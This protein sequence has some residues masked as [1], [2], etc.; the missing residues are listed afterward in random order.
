ML[1][2]QKL[3]DF[4]LKELK[5]DKIAIGSI[6]RLKNAPPDMNPLNMMP[7]A[8]SVI[9]FA[10]RILRG[11]YRGID[12]GTHWPS[13]QV[14]GYSGLN[15][16]NSK[17][18]YRLGR[19]VESFGYEAMPAPSSAS[20]REFGPRGPS[21]K[22]GKPPREITLNLRI[23]AAS[24][25]LGEIGWSKVFLTEEFGPRQRIGIILTEAELEPDPIPEKKLCDGC[26]QCVR[27]CPGCAL[28]KDKSVEIELNG[29][30]V[31]WCDIDIG[32]C[33]LT[34]F[35]LNRKSSPHFVKR[36]PGVYLPVEQQ[37][38]TWLEAW[39]LGWAIFPFVPTYASL[40]SHPVPIC[41]ARGCIVACMKHLEKKGV[42]KNQ[43]VNKRG[44]SDNKPWSLPEKPPHT[45]H[46]GFVYE[47]KYQSSEDG[48]DSFAPPSDWY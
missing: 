47:P 29:K 17:T 22:P 41:G 36:F 15:H 25:G 6:E 13:Y 34:H 11:C 24:T 21:P 40:S 14:F 2:S 46:H 35:G 39:D 8:K 16:V 32:K 18:L 45:G 37:E 12:E 28:P 4:A 30:K 31:S 42:V 43:F 23:A 7:R 1:N 19:F 9:A 26:K 38:L 27:E 5:V 33:K 48:K 3:K 20:L 44:F 10:Q